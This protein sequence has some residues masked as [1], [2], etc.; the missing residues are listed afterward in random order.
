MNCFPLSIKIQGVQK[1]VIIGNF[2]DF[3][4]ALLEAG[5]SGAVNGAGGDGVFALFRYGWGADD[6]SSLFWHSG[7]PETDPWEWRMRVLEERK[8]IAYSKVFFRKAGYITRKWYPYFLAARRG[9]RTFDDDCSGGKI[10]RSAKRIY[11]AVAGNG[12]LPLHEIK[13]AAAFRREDNS[14][15]DAAL[16]DLQ[17]KLYVT[18]CGRQPK[19]SRDGEEYG[20]ASTVFCTTETFW[21]RAVFD[22]AAKIGEEE[23]VEKI[24]AQILKLNPAA[25]EKKILRFIKG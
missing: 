22:R 20:W 18:M 8:D 25:D 10:S 24:S 2:S 7:D 17:M 6:E 14:R 16:T 12:R 5:F 21:G 15:F 13:L 1:Y 9:G 11:E 23:A 19:I 3:T 4:A